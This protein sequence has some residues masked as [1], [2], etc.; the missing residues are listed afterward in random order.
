[1][2]SFLEFVIFILFCLYVFKESLSYGIYEYKNENKFGGVF[3][4]VFSL[5]SIILSIV[6]LCIAW[7][8]WGTDSFFP[9][10]N[11]KI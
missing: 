3:V 2:I 11:Y 8:I 4:I 10:L 7:G 6:A 5:F 9:F 1:M